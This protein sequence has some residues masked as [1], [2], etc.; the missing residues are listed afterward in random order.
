MTLGVDNLSEALGSDKA[1]P[2]ACRRR[3]DSDKEAARC[4]EFTEKCLLRLRLY[5]SSC[6][7]I[8]AFVAAGNKM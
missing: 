3:L 8:W 6:Q 1:E 2:V 5:H 4:Q 7:S